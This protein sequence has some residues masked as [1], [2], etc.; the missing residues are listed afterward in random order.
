MKIIKNPEKQPKMC[1]KVIWPLNVVYST[2]VENNERSW[3]S[4]KSAE[5]GADDHNLTENLD[6]P[7]NFKQIRVPETPH[8]LLVK[9]LKTQNPSLN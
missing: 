8:L 2:G 7:W 1:A 4:P 5:K 3:K 9:L 6:S